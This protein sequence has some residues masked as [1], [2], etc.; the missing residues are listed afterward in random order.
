MDELNKIQRDYKNLVKQF[1]E[2]VTA[3]NALVDAHDGLLKFLKIQCGVLYTAITGDIHV[4]DPLK[5]ISLITITD[6][7]SKDLHEFRQGLC[8]F[9]RT[10]EETGD[11]DKAFEAY[12][13][14][15]GGM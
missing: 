7:G 12:Q 10:Y 6:E 1:N 11:A 3:H 8:V 4:D 9:V 13:N 2:M 5:M 14:Y 15:L